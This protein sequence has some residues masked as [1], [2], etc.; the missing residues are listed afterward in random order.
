MRTEKNTIF[1]LKVFKSQDKAQGTVAKET[2]KWLEE[3]DF[4]KTGGEIKLTIFTLAY[5]RVYMLVRK[6]ESLLKQDIKEL[7]WLIVDDTSI[8]DTIEVTKE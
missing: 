3:F 6:Y 7:I 8:D 4:T 1:I 5:N 2:A